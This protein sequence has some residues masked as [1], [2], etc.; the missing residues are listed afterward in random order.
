MV[1]VTMV[2]VKFMNS[3]SIGFAG[4]GFGLKYFQVALLGLIKSLTIIF[5]A[6]FE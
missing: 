1:T 4:V 6:P 3:L 5:T 2:I